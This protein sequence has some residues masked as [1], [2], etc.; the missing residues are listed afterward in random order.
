MNTTQFLVM[1]TVFTG[2]FF[3]QSQGSAQERQ[4]KTVSPDGKTHVVWFLDGWDETIAIYD[5]RTGK[6]KHRI[7]GHGDVVQEFRYS[8]DGQV[9]AA[10]SRKGWRIWNVSN[11]KQLMLLRA[12]NTKT[13]SKEPETDVKAVN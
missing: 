7:T 13:Q 6:L 8:T 2:I 3:V 1:S 10:K 11:G 12:P 9:L 5:N 4:L